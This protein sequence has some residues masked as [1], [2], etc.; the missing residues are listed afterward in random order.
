MLSVTWIAKFTY[1]SISDFHSF[2]EYD[3]PLA[4]GPNLSYPYHFIQNLLNALL[5]LLFL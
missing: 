4:I 2:L 1:P 5:V 3:V